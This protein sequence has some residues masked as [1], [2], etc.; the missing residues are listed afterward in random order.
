MGLLDKIGGYFTG[1]VTQ[2][3][4]AIG[5]TD[6]EA[7]GRAY[8]RQSVAIDRAN[9][10]Q[11]ELYDEGKERLAPY[12][13]EGEISFKDLIG[14]IKN[15]K[16][17]SDADGKFQ[18]H[19][20]VLGETD[21]KKD[22][23]YDFRMKEGQKAIERMAAANGRLNS[24]ATMKE[25]Q[26][27]GQNMASNEYQNAYNRFNSDYT[28]AYNR[29]N[30]DQSRNLNNMRSLV[31]YGMDAN[32][33]LMGL[34]SRY[35]NSTANNAMALG[36]AGAAYEMNKGQ[37]MKELW[38]MGTQ[39]AAMAYGACWVARA[40]FGI[41]DDR[42]LLARHYIVNIG[43]KWFKNIYLKHG[44]EFAKKVEN[45]PVLKKIL[46]PLFI[47]FAFRGATNRR[48]SLC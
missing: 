45:S 4:D 17:F 25:L 14:L 26:R 6:S 35:G 32:N 30:F 12:L 8:D 29:Y 46:K 39:A 19:S 22:P 13:E 16:N 42:W 20:G 1:G 3:T 43:P 44:E 31:N 15:S 9:K 23:G 27:Y 33:A 24:G 18:G 40:V 10:I 36:N 7:G 5:L 21:F 28:N 2:Y 34:N 11:K 41:N 38:E 47:Y 48:E 37:T